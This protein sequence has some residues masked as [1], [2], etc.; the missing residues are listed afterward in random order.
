VAIGL[1]LLFVAGILAVC[2]G[3]IGWMFRTGY[4]L[5]K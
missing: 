5:K 4:R 1:S 2:I 3:I